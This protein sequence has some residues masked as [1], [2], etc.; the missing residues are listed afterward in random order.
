[1]V[2]TTTTITI[3]ILLQADKV[4]DIILHHARL[5]RGGVSSVGLACTVKQDLLKVPPDVLC[6]DRGVVEHLGVLEEWD[7]WVTPAQDPGVERDSIL[8]VHIAAAEERE[9]RVESLTRA[10]MAH[11]VDEF[12]R[13]S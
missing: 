3:T 6:G 13:V 2:T 1:M 8:S 11:C 7:S 12:F 4:L 5:Y 10:H 9:V